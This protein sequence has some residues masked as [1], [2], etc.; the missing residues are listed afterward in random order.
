[1]Q[2]SRPESRQHESNLER[3]KMI[4]TFRIRDHRNLTQ[5]DQNLTT[6]GYEQGVSLFDRASITH[7]DLVAEEHLVLTGRGTPSLEQ[8]Q[9]SWSW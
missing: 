3:E 8:R 2:G 9:V 6:C 1:M 5:D 4:S 7:I